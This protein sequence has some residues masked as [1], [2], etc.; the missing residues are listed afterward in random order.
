MVIRHKLL[1]QLGRISHFLILALAERAFN[2]EQLAVLTALQPVQLL[3]IHQR[4]VD[5]RIIQGEQLS[6]TGKNFAY[7]LQCLHGKEASFWLDAQ[8][9][10]P[11]VLISAT[12]P[13]LAEIP[14]DAIIVDGAGR[15]RGGAR[16]ESTLQ[17]MRLKDADEQCAWLAWLFPA[18]NNIPWVQDCWW[19]EWELDL[20]VSDKLGVGQGIALSAP[21]VDAALVDKPAVVL[22]SQL[23][24]LAIRYTVSDSLF[25]SCDAA[26]SP[27]Q[28]LYFDYFSEQIF[29]TA[30]SFCDKGV[31]GIEADSSEADAI[32]ALKMRVLERLPESAG[33]ALM[34]RQFSLDTCWRPLALSWADV[35]QR[36]EECGYNWYGRGHDADC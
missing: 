14:E 13:A 26:L 16:E 23:L 20:G 15:S 28:D 34:N 1:S 22:S 8:Y 10:R 27:N 3:P 5:I 19:T 6:N 18:F 2:L 25:T 36:L 21:P 33:M 31:K 7:Y 17:L 11:P 4:L 32:A 29:E 30:G 35:G 9:R 24:H 12:H